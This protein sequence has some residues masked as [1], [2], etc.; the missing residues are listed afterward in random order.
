VTVAEDWGAPVGPNGGYVA[1]LVLG[2][3]QASLPDPAR[4]PRSLTLH[5]TRSP[6]EGREAVVEVVQER[7]GGSL[8]TVS[9]RLVQDDRLCVVALG[10]FAADYESAGTYAA[11]PPQAPPPEAIEP[12]RM[13]DSSPAL[14]RRLDMRPAFG[15]P[16]FRGSDDGTTGG[17]LALA[18]PQPLTATALA[19]YADAW[20]PV[21]WSRMTELVMAPTIDLTLHFRNAPRP[22][23]AG[24]V[25]ARFSTR[26]AAEGFYEEDGEL[27]SSDGVLLVQ[28]RQLALLRPSRPGGPSA[29]PAAEHPASAA[30][31]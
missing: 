1:A 15:P 24:P 29:A 25:L 23:D 27:W 17:W 2:A 18:E 6:K 10:S 8:S 30:R 5:Y 3:M 7:T 14:L 16:P 20:W 13:R 11:A 22:D 26:T 9:A 4:R 21:A 19:L 28:S 31:P 12:V